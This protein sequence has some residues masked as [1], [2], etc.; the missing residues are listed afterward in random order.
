MVT[1]TSEA[2][3]SINHLK[4]AART[5][6]D[7][8]KSVR[9]AKQRNDDDI[10]IAVLEKT[11]DKLGRVLEGH[12]QNHPIWDSFLEPLKGV[13]GPQMAMVVAEIGSPWRF[14]GQPCSIRTK[15]TPN[16]HLSD[17]RYPIGSQCP[18]EEW[19]DKDTED[20]KTESELVRCVGVMETPRPHTGVRAL[21]RYCNIAPDE[22]T[23]RVPRK[24]KNVKSLWNHRIKGSVIGP[25][26]DD[27]G[28][29]AQIIRHR[30]EPYRTIYD[31]AKARVREERPDEPD[32]KTETV[33]K[34]I[35]LRALMGDLLIAMKRCMPLEDA[36]PGVYIP[37][38]R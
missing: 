18:R 29:A 21:M 36:L 6:E 31:E 38:P 27:M 5:H 2:P 4:V 37:S 7:A 13:R 30:V 9:R 25:Q 22:K 8:V 28:I 16:G 23:K 17:P 32:Y 19:V 34:Y 20:G 3:A 26:G 35:A 1:E 11:K 33:A 24:Q 14:P 12:L 15:D 10:S